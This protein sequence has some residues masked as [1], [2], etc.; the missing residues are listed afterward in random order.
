M[1]FQLLRKLSSH[2]HLFSNEQKELLQVPVSVMIIWAYAFFLTAGGAY[3]FKGCSPDIPNSNILIDA[4]QKHANTMRHCRTDVS[5]AMRTAAWVRIPYPFQWG[6]PTF[7][8]RTSIIMVIVSLV[9]S[10][11]SVS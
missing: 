4:C 6:I 11:D 10:I 8:L 1:I 3:N 9:A 2:V 5:N 7:R